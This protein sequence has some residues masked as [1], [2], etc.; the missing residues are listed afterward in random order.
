MQVR[1]SSLY[2]GCP[3]ATNPLNI[4]HLRRESRDCR[5]FGGVELSRGWRVGCFIGWGSGTAWVLRLVGIGDDTPPTWPRLS[6]PQSLDS[7][8]PAPISPVG[9]CAGSS[10]CSQCPETRI[11]SPG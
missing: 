1:R 4:N 5:D 6:D 10:T 2:D 3:S 8:L 11:A 7:P 9:S